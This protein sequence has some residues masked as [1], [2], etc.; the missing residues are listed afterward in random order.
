MEELVDILTKTDSAEEYSRIWDPRWIFYFTLFW[1]LHKLQNNVLCEGKCLSL[2]KDSN[3]KSFSPC[4][5]CVR[6]NVFPNV[7]AISSIVNSISCHR[8]NISPAPAPVQ[9]YFSVPSWEM[10]VGEAGSWEELH[11]IKEFNL[12]FCI[13]LTTQDFPLFHT[14]SSRDFPSFFI[15]S[16]LWRF[17]SRSGFIDDFYVVRKLMTMHNGGLFNSANTQQNKRLKTQTKAASKLVFVENEHWETFISRCCWNFLS[18]F[19]TLVVPL[20]L[21]ISSIAVKFL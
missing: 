13:S 12:E 15:L 10:C 21:K 19:R 1:T 20:P 4:L 8:T 18:H 9:M 16:L 3:F 7:I 2:H 6:K 17:A 5:D 11:Q 14:I